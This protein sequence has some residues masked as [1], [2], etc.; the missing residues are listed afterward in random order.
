MEF[1]QKEVNIP[2]QSSREFETEAATQLTYALV[3]PQLAGPF[4]QVGDD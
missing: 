2:F 1:F 4:A 3:N